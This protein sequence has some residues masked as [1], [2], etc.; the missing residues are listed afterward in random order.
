MLQYGCVNL[1]GSRKSLI[2]SLAALG[3][4]QSLSIKMVMSNSLEEFVVEGVLVMIVGAIGMALN[5]IRYK[6][7]QTVLDELVRGSYKV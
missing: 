5:I 7:G 2:C 1:H 3:V 4:S 6:P